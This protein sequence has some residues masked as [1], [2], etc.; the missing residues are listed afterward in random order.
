[1]QQKVTLF[2]QMSTDKCIRRESYETLDEKLPIVVEAPED[3][4]KQ[5]YEE[6]MSIDED[7]QIAATVIDFEICQAVCEQD[8]AINVN[9]SD[10]DECVEEN[11]PT[12]DEM[13]Q[14]F[15]NTNTKST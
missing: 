15:D 6:R 5:A 7:I 4:L 1:M 12:N 3:V 8:Q 10:R 13:R 11:P 2:T 9:D 14:E